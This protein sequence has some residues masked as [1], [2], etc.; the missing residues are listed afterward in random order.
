[1]NTKITVT[2]ERRAGF[3]RLRWND[4]KRRS[5]ALGLRDT[6]ANWNFATAKK[7]EIEND[8]ND[9]TYDATLLK[10]KPQTTGSNAS[11][12]SAPELFRKFTAHKIK[13]GDISEHTA[14][15][16]YRGLESSLR[17]YL[18]K[19]VSSIDRK[20]A[21]SL[22]EIFAQSIVPLTAKS[23]LGLLKA[24][25]DWAKGNYQI[26][27]KN[28]WDGLGKKFKTL[29]KKELNPWSGDEVRSIISGFKNSKNYCH[30]TD[31]VI[32]LFG[33][34]CRQGEAVALKWG[35]VT[36]SAADNSSVWIGESQTG[37]YKNPTTKTK[38]AR[39]VILP[40]TI[41]AMLKARKEAR[42]PQPG[43]LVFPELD[44]HSLIDCCKFR[45]KWERLLKS[46]GVRYSRPYSTRH[47]A[48]SHAL[49]NGAR[50]IDVA[51]ACG[52]SIQTL[53]EKYAHVIQQKQVFTEFL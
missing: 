17:K 5:L 14:S 19:S 18:D 46:V 44:G 51:Q 43:E 13:C 9:Q 52:H 6:P 23:R 40:P 7:K 24:C 42:N 28:P 36:L 25:W 53:L 50:P 41:A 2:I 47:T 29:D 26:D 48:I 21:D 8:W 49:E 38:R 34:G 3:L 45:H 32:F 33:I 11:D 12:I 10:Y 1:M 16:A 27:A 39:T 22:A 30:Y 35:S 15:I 31:F 20:A 37:K 4:G